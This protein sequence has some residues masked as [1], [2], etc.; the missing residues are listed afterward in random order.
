[1]VFFSAYVSSIVVTFFEVYPQLFGLRLHHL[2][3]LPR[4]HVYFLV[5]SVAQQDAV[6]DALPKF[7][8]SAERQDVVQL[9][10]IVVEGLAAMWT[11]PP[12]AL[13]EFPFI[14]Y[15]MVL[16][17]VI[18]HQIAD[19]SLLHPAIRDIEVPPPDVECL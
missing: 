8:E 16:D 11:A 7:G 19:G 9:H 13:I 12:L 5:A 6:A 17:E 10:L 2:D 3:V 15:T 1:M 18:I 4:I 14:C